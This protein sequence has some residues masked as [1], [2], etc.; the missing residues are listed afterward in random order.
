MRKLSS[1]QVAFSPDGKMI[2][3]GGHWDNSVRGFNVFEKKTTFH[4]LWHSDVITCL[5]IDAFGTRLI[6]GSADRSCCIWSIESD[7]SLGAKPSLTL[8]GHSSQISD[9]RYHTNFNVLGRLVL[10]DSTWLFISDSTFSKFRKFW[11]KISDY[12]L[13]NLKNFGHISDSTP[14]SFIL[15]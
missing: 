7:A 9:V 13:K 6:S 11:S 5:A 15:F 12:G 14:I 1:K 10:S 4:C 3:S 2:Y 8:F